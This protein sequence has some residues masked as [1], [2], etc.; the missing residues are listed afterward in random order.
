VTVFVVRVISTYVT[1]YRT[2]IKKEYWNELANGCP[3][4]QSITVTRWPASSDPLNGLDLAEP[5]GRQAVLDAF[6]RLYLVLS[7]YQP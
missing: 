6:C 2:T 1:F 5:N 7:E 3:R 4:N